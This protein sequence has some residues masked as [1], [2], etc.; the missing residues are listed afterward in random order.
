MIRNSQ[1]TKVKFSKSLARTQKEVET[2]YVFRNIN[3]IS[4]DGVRNGQIRKLL[5]RCI[6]SLYLYSLKMM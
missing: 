2:V 6:N 3:T 5:R 4:H 1:A